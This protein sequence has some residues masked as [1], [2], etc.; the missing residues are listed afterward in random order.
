MAAFLQ[1]AKDAFLKRA[2]A[3]VDV[4]AATWSYCLATTALLGIMLFFDGFPSSARVLVA[5]GRQ[6]TIRGREPA[7]VFH[8]HT[9]LGPVPD[10]AHAHLSPL[11]CWSQVRS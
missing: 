1:A 7:S 8:G 10:P 4:V 2:M 9:R 11:S 6:R 5:R 3:D